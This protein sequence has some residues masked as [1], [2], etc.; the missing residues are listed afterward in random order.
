MVW[1]MAAG[2]GIGVPPSVAASIPQLER[3]WRGLLQLERFGAS[4]DLW[5]CA[6]ARLLRTQWRALATT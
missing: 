3:H 1:G 2:A 6:V 5:D 4:P